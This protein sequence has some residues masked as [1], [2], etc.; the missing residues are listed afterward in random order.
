MIYDSLSITDTGRCNMSMQWS[1]QQS[2]FL[3]WAKNGTGSCVLEAVAGAGKTTTLVAAVR[4]LVGTT[5]IVAY[6]KKIAEELQER[7]NGMPNAKA[8]TVH[9]FG[10]AAIR[11]AFG[12]VKVSSY[13]VENIV[14]ELINDENNTK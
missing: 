11:K 9:S 10:F 5:A 2:A 13:K 1:P 8:G 12:S 3:A 4:D 14:T 7:I 6:N